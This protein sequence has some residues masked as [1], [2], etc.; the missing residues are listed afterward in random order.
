MTGG[1]AAVTRRDATGVLLATGLCLLGASYA[2]AAGRAAYQLGPFVAVGGAIIPGDVQEVRTS[3]YHRPGAGAAVYVQDAAVDATYLARHPTSAFRSADGRGFRLRVETP[4]N[5]EAL[6]LRLGL[7]PGF[8]QGNQDAIAGALLLCRRIVLPAGDIDFRTDSGFILPALD[9]MEIAGQGW[10]TRIVTRDSAFLLPTLR[11]LTIRDLWIEQVATTRS[12]IQSFHCNLRAIRFLRLKITMADQARHQNNCIGLVM[13]ESPIGS[14]G[15]IGLYGLSI[16]DCWL[17]PG[18]MGVEIQ[19]HRDLKRSYGYQKVTMQG[20]TV[21]KA[22]VSAGMGV[23]LSG[24]GVDCLITKNR[25]VGCHGPSVEIIGGD[26][27]SVIGNVF[28]DAIGAPIA[29]SNFRVARDCRIINNRTIGSPSVNGLFLE[30]V[31]RLEVSSNRFDTKGVHVLKGS[32]IHLHDNELVGTG[33]AQLIHLDH[34]QGVVIEKNR[35]L[36]VGAAERRPMVVAFNATRN[37]V[38][39]FNKLTRWDYDVLQDAQWFAQGSEVRHSSVY[40]NERC[41][42]TGCL[43]DPRSP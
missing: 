23:S 16:E 27:T 7:N 1:T 34:A 11:D 24:W 19:Y 37:C 40:G 9:G 14:D 42:R 39:R 41:G 33:T 12:A 22:P 36:S 30:A 31:D 15:K 18:R 2:D 10:A 13:D 28:E 3:G 25:F 43:K 6:G 32:R 4:C 8:A 35:L 20:C 17:A 38:I 21:W 29:A 5:P 26:R